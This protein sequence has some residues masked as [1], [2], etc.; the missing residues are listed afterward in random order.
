MY[1]TSGNSNVFL[2]DPFYPFAST[3]VYGDSCIGTSA[4]VA[5]GQLL[6]VTTAATANFITSGVT[7]AAGAGGM[8]GLGGAFDQTAYVSAVDNVWALMLA[9]KA[10]RERGS[11]VLVVGLR[12]PRLAA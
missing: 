10:R 6:S 8:P 9:G 3:W 2:M 5:P 7:Y 1:F 12:G 11:L 4:G